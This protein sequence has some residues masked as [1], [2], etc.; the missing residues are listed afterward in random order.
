MN[1]V[2]IK[3]VENKK[4]VHQFLKFAFK[5]YEGDDNWV[6]PLYFDK[7]KILN[8]KKNPFFEH[9]DMDLFLAYRDNEIVGRIAAITN[10][11]HNKEYSDK[12]GFFGFFECLNDQEAANKL[13]DTAKEWLLE[14]GMNAM[15]GPASPSVNDE[16]ALLIDGFDD[17]PRLMM[18]YNPKYYMD[19][20]D[21]YGFEKAKDLYAYKIENHKLMQSG[22]LLRIAD[23]AQRRSKMTMRSINM[24]KFDSELS[25]VKMVY[26]KAWQQHWGFVPFTDAEIDAAAADLKPL[27]DPNLVLFAEADG[28]TIGF[29]LVMPDYNFIF[30]EMKGKLFPFNFL[31]LYTK[32]KSIPWARILILGL[33][34]EFQKRGLDASLYV[35][36]AKRAHERGII[37]GEASWILEDNVMMNRG[38]KAMNGE[39]YKTYRVYQIE[40]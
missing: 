24:K 36:I 5:V 33:V 11:L 23:I 26:N 31:K 13:F 22:K 2:T 30:K 3:K 14:K 27:V 4:D 37:L 35:E 1:S 20:I 32:R 6:P 40:I 34:P 10:A 21:N 29:A 7:K 17:P 39:V 25:L 38:A 15:R 12:V 28:K 8:K 9:A 16:Y 19:L 18:S